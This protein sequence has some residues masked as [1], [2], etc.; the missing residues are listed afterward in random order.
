[1]RM[2]DL[3]KTANLAVR[4]LAGLLLALSF[5]NTPGLAAETDDRLEELRAELDQAR[6]YVGNY[7]EGNNDPNPV[8]R[9]FLGLGTDDKPAGSPIPARQLQA[10]LERAVALSSAQLDNRQAAKLSALINEATQ[11]I[12]QGWLISGNISLMEGLRV[13]YPNEAGDQQRPTYRPIP[14][15]SPENDY[16]F[17]A[18]KDASTA[19]LFYD[20]GVRVLLRSMARALPDPD[21]R[22]LVDIDVEPL[23][24]DLRE[25]PGAF[26]NQQF[27]QYTYYVDRGVPGDPAD[28]R[29]VPIQTQG[30]MMGNLL[31]KQ[32][33]A[34]ASIGYR[35]WTAAYFSKAPQRDPRLGSK[36]LDEAVDQF[37]GAA[38]TQFLASIALAA[39]VGDKAV[40]TAES[41]YATDRLHFARTNVEEARSVVGQIRAKQKPTLPTDEIMA[42]NAQ[43][44]A[45]LQVL[46]DPNGG[47]GSLRRAETAYTAAKEAL[48][49]VHQQ[50]QQ[51]FQEEQTRQRQFLDQLE[52][53][54][55][56][57]VP[58]EPSINSAAGQAR[59]RQVVADRLTAVLN[60]PRPALGDIQNR[61]DEAIKQVV[62]QRQQ[63][64]NKKAAL[65]SYPLRI[66]IIE[67]TLGANVSAIRE[68]EGKITAAQLAQ[69]IANSISITQVAGV[70]I[71]PT[72]PAAYAGVQ[73]TRNPG[74]IQAAQLQNDITRAANLKEMKFLENE[75]AA[76]IRNLLVDQDLAHGELRSQLI[77]LSNAEDDVNKVRGD[78]ERLLTQLRDF[79][80]A[81]AALW[82]RDPV[83]NIEL[84][85]K[86][87]EANRALDGAVRNLYKLG[88]MLELRWIEPFSNP[89]SVLSGEPQSLGADYDNFWS[90]ESAFML[91]AV[92]VRDNP[93]LN[94]PPDQA[95]DFLRALRAWDQK[96]RNLRNFDGDLSVINVSLRQ[97]VFGLADVK[98]VNGVTKYLDTNPV[99]PEYLK[100]KALRDSNIRRFQNLLIN[101]GLF[102]QTEP[103]KP[104][105][106]LLRFPIRYY[107]MGFTDFR[108]GNTRLFGTIPA[109][110]YRLTKFK[111]KIISLPGRTAFPQ[112]TAEIMFAQ[113]GTVENIDFFE[114]RLS[115]R[116]NDQ[117]RLRQINLDNYLRYDPNDLGA[118][119]GS[120][121][122][123]FSKAK[124]GDFLPDSEI[125]QASTLGPRFWS[126]FASRWQ[127]QL[128]PMNLLEIENIDDIVIEMSL[129][130]GVPDELP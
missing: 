52:Q 64:F 81:T 36:M 10:I 13:A 106:F 43:V 69:G 2:F 125:V 48:F 126:P 99:N 30:Y 47:P 3:R 25:L 61:L 130:S 91:G 117:R 26:A 15:G 129:A 39:T 105:G 120:P 24:Q 54:T 119:A 42:G 21:G 108:L 77:L 127:L 33:Q 50:E 59:Y 28:D 66:K 89:V 46:E 34:L 124:K 83:W 44:R 97:D 58:S 4:L 116:S 109:W 29:I 94:T 100:D 62:F 90:L 17:V 57:K 70:Q 88:K 60:D 73:I 16:N 55:G 78:A 67:D 86:E 45:V 112:P 1:M 6:L 19:K 102:L 101:N 5:G 20:E 56:I 12:L 41:P 35:I 84:T 9:R 96:L 7:P 65:D 18:T 110:N 104:R 118:S 14:Y 38:N 80:T 74:A 23:P 79:N 87:E 103:N 92:N 32:G 123:L 37:H 22:L 85:G 75:A 71:S 27:P 8:R 107:A 72:G 63:V 121:Y 68:A 49:R 98:T 51:V 122:L 95:R 76:R 82:Y 128:N 53:L 31:Q 114:R 11:L 113:S 40:Q 115:S 111:V 93:D